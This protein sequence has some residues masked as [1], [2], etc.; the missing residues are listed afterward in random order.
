VAPKPILVDYHRPPRRA[1]DEILFCPASIPGI[2]ALQQDCY[3]LIG[4][5]EEGL[6]R[7]FGVPLSQLPEALFVLSQEVTNATERYAAEVRMAYKSAREA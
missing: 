3:D 4:L 6:D 2:K 7:Y 1:L 5:K